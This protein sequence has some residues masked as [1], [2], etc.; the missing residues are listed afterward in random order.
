MEYVII[1]IFIKGSKLFLLSYG[2]NNTVRSGRLLSR[3]FHKHS[4]MNITITT[5]RKLQQTDAYKLWKTGIISYYTYLAFLIQIYLGKISEL[6]YEN[7][8]KMQGHSP[9]TAKEYYVKDDRYLKKKHDLFYL[10]LI[11]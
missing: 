3:F 7:C 9:A 10:I 1:Y 5:I 6:E 2:S 11:L 4:K 8:C